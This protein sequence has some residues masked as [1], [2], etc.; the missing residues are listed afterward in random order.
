MHGAMDIRLFLFH[1]RHSILH[2]LAHLEFPAQTESITETGFESINLRRSIG[3]R[4][5]YEVAPA[6]FT[7][8]V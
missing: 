5:V 3:R 1:A 7:G 4:T 6:N 8:I 2:L